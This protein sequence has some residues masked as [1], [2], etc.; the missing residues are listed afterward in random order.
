MKLFP[1]LIKIHHISE[2]DFIYLPIYIYSSH[3]HACLFALFL[4][5]AAQDPYT[6]GIAY[7]I[8]LNHPFYGSH[9]KDLELGKLGWFCVYFFLDDILG[10]SFLVKG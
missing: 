5:L 8:N 7:I 3:L 2:T 10:M 9:L 4:F 1:Y 6:Q